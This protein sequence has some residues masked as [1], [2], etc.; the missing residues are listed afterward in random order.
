MI[1]SNILTIFAIIIFIG[2]A[3]ITSLADQFNIIPFWFA[4]M[5]Y[6]ILFIY[7]VVQAVKIVGRFEAKEDS[8]KY[9]NKR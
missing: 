2:I 9:Q 3:S 7:I 1:K 4:I 8:L 5:V 6:A